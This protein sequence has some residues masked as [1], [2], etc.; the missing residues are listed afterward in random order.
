MPYG[1]SRGKHEEVFAPVQLLQNLRDLIQSTRV[2]I[3]QAVNSALAT[4]INMSLAAVDW[5]F[6]QSG[7][8]ALMYQS[9]LEECRSSGCQIA[10]TRISINNL[11]VL[12]LFTRLEC[13]VRNAVVTLHRVAPLGTVRPVPTPLRKEQSRLDQPGPR[14]RS[15]N[16][17]TDPDLTRQLEEAAHLS[18]QAKGLLSKF[19]GSPA[20]HTTAGRR[21][22]ASHGLRHSWHRCRGG[23]FRGQDYVACP[24]LW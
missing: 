22:V 12:N 23:A 6:Q 9:V 1:K 16:P 2:G 5:P 21:D 10:S 8:G 17:R 11:D 19:N 20:V 15:A 18:P 24:S 4:A 7:L 13:D 14:A 3:A